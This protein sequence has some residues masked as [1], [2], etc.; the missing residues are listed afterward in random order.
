MMSGGNKKAGL[1]GVI[2]V[3]LGSPAHQIFWILLPLLLSPHD[4]SSFFLLIILEQRI[5]IG[6]QNEKHF[7]GVKG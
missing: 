4:R 6:A 5:V 2:L 3:T 1:R 7:N